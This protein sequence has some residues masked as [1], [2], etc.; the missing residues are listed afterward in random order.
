MKLSPKTQRILGAIARH[1]LA[2]GG[3]YLA[4][5]GVPPEAIDLIRDDVA[6]G[7]GGILAAGA[8]AWSVCQKAKPDAS[9]RATE[10]TEPRPES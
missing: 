8:A 9:H 6:R 4:T 2:A 7:S 10:G 3:I 1:A 5:K